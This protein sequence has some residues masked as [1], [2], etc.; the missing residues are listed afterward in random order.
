MRKQ[1]K[2]N[3]R[4]LKSEH[5][6]RA[7]MRANKTRWETSKVNNKF[8]EVNLTNKQKKT[9]MRLLVDLMRVREWVE[10]RER[11]RDAKQN[12]YLAIFSI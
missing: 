10:M 1:K 9:R 5:N 7:A 12:Y 2:S 4:E 3:F 8:R 6:A 11:E